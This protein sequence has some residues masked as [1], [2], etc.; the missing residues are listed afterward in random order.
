[1]NSATT[2]ATTDKGAEILNAV[3]M[4]GI[5]LG[6]RIF[7][8]ICH[9]LAFREFIMSNISGSMIVNPVIVLT[10][11]GKNVVRKVIT[12][13]GRRPTPIHVMKTGAKAAVGMEF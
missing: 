11:M 6:S 2:A 7:R 13:F 10:V 12:N 9:L 1:M 8:Y 5:D 4:Y 3:N